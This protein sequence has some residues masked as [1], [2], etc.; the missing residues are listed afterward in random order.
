MNV[1]PRNFS[2]HQRSWWPVLRE[3]ERE[4]MPP[5]PPVVVPA[6]ECRGDESWMPSSPKSIA[7]R[8]RAGGWWVRITRAIGPR[9][10]AHGTVPEGREQVA[11]IAVAAARG[12]D[13]LVW[14][15]KYQTTPA[16]GWHWKLDE[17]FWNR[18][19]LIDNNKG[20]AVLDA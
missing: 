3:R 10:D 12:T 18:E 4:P 2:A 8:A 6:T 5:L 15:W 9:V 11:T 17:V 13:R 16:K 7:K 20:G 1:A 19:G 14:V